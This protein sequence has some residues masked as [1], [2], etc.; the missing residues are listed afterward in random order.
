MK[1]AFCG[2][3]L[4]GAPMVRRLLAAGHEVRVWNRTAAKAAPL[5][6]LGAQPAA[7]PA[8]AAAGADGVLMCLFDAAAA[9]AVVFGPEGVAAAP[10]L[11]WLADHSTI[12]P[13]ATRALA[14]RLARERDAH[15]LDAPVSGG[16]AGAEAGTLAIMVGGE[17][18]HLDE[19]RAA[20]RAYAGN[21]THMGPPGAGQA[22]KLCN[23]T[24]VATTVLAIAEAVGF[25]R[26]NGI[27]LERLPAA[28]AG[29][30]ADSRP[31]QVFVPRMAQPQPEIIGALSTMLKD[32]D[33]V[34]AV[35]RDRGAPMPLVAQV[36]QLLRLAA[37]AGLAEAELSAVV[38]LVWPEQR[39][40]FL[41]QAAR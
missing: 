41:R 37:A 6:A 28:L 34:M 2:L 29:G 24:I 10:G 19:A 8:Q 16:V 32:V 31:L 5:L 7:T 21:V 4:M 13:D 36:Q 9:E 11:R 38:S 17:T 1:L 20:L 26:R 14:A 18:R 35:A 23:Q 25:A 39:E 30:W 15:W 12:D 40:A 22:T 33:T 27:A 3:G